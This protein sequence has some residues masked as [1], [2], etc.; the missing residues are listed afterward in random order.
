MSDSP[1]RSNKVGRSAVIAFAS[2]MIFTLLSFAVTALT[3]LHYGAATVGV[4][5]IATTIS[6]IGG[7]FGNLGTSS[8]ATYYISAYVHGSPPGGVRHAYYRGAVVCLGGCILVSGLAFAGR[9]SM[10]ALGLSWEGLGDDALTALALTIACMWGRSYADLTAAAIRATDDVWGFSVLQALPALLSLIILEIGHNLG[11]G[12]I[13]AIWAYVGG[14]VLSALLGLVWMEIRLQGIQIGTQSDR[15]VPSLQTIARY[16]LP[17]MISTLGG[18]VVTATGVLILSHFASEESVGY[19]AIALRLATTTS[20]I[21]TSINAIT[22]PMFARLHHSGQQAEI[23]TLGK[24][25]ARMMF[26]AVAPVA[27]GLVLLGRP[28]LQIFFGDTF[29]VAY[30]PMVI[31]LAGQLINT[32]TGP[33]DFIMNM[34]GRQRQ[35]QLIIIPSAALS[36]FLGAVLAGPYAEVGSAIAYSASLTAWNLMVALYLRRSLGGWVG[37]LPVFSGLARKR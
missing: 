36:V 3:A 8:S 18:Y 9:D 5:A 31:L 23:V 4:V 15:E 11:A 37:Y 7:I 27:L 21:L 17:T 19:F 26:W 16:S 1:A 32:L 28:F 35:L 10:L 20:L 14:I 25:T 30:V 24:S 34:T 2:R 13:I 22:T 29:V 12:P 33:S 6:T